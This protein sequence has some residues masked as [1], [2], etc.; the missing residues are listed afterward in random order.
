MFEGP[1]F[2][3]I[4]LNILSSVKNP[5][6]HFNPIMWTSILKGTIGAQRL[7]CIN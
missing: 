7:S 1:F 3:H 2:R 6:K 5:I 4:K